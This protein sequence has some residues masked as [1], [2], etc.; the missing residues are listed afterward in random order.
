MKYNT[1]LTSTL[2]YLESLLHYEDGGF[3][4]NQRNVHKLSRKRRLHKAITVLQCP[5]KAKKYKFLSQ[6]Y[7][8]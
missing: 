5:L 3:L 6:N 7:I 8:L 1:N 2:L 4:L